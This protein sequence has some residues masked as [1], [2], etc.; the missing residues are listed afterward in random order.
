MYLPLTV[1]S[2]DSAFFERKASPL[3]CPLP[4]YVPS[5][6]SFFPTTQSYYSKTVTQHKI[7]KIACIDYM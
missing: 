4:S 7:T 6:M 1:A 3:P 5:G 2:V